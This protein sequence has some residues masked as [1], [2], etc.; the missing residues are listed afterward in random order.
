[1]TDDTLY[2]MASCTKVVAA[3]SAVMKLY[4]MGLIQLED[5]IT[6]WVPEADNN[7]KGDITIKNLLL[8]NAGLPPDCPYVDLPE[9]GISPGITE[10][11]FLYWLYNSELMYPTGT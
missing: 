3:T 10:E 8:H 7:G 4:D 6:K 11:E 2:D 9:Y 1:M 5:K